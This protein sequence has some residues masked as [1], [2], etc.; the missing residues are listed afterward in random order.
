MK[1]P[2]F[3]QRILNGAES[4][5]QAFAASAE[6]DRRNF[7][8][9][10]LQDPHTIAYRRE[11]V[12][13]LYEALQ[14]ESIARSRDRDAR[15][16]RAESR[17]ADYMQAAE[18]LNRQALANSKQHG[19]LYILTDSDDGHQRTEWVSNPDQTKGDVFPGSDPAD[20]LEVRPCYLDK[21]PEHKPMPKSKA[22]VKQAKMIGRL[23]DALSEI[24][25][26]SETELAQD[27]A[28]LFRNLFDQWQHRHATLIEAAHDGD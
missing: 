14:Q 17:A 21:A 13:W 11:V 18:E 20:L 7:I 15:I 4:D 23:A 22:L 5:A 2:L 10:L 28:E 24:V 8:G 26:S 27:D 9:R 6:T 1:Q 19:Y 16:T 25:A 3:S 12:Q